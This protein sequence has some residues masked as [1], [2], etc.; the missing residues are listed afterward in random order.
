MLSRYPMAELV[1]AECHLV[2]SKLP[3][4]VKDIIP[5]GRPQGCISVAQVVKSYRTGCNFSQFFCQEAVI[6]PLTFGVGEHE[7][8]TFIFCECQFLF[9]YV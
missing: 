1:D 5:I 2:V 7:S 3:G 9:C 6:A 4:N 8:N